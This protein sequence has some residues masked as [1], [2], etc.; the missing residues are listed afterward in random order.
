MLLPSLPF[1][2]RA[3]RVLSTTR[4]FS[5]G[6]GRPCRPDFRNSTRV[7]PGGSA[8]A[9]PPPPLRGLIL[10]A[11]ATPFLLR[12]R[13]GLRRIRP[14][15]RGSHREAV[16]ALGR[17]GG[18]SGPRARGA[19]GSSL[20]IGVPAF[21]G[22]GGSVQARRLRREGRPPAGYLLL[23]R[24][25]PAGPPPGDER[26]L[27]PS[28][29]PLPEARSRRAARGRQREPRGPEPAR[30]GAGA[31]PP[32]RP[33]LPA[34][35]R[36]AL[37]RKRRQSGVTAESPSPPRP[38]AGPA[39]PLSDLGQPSPSDWRPVL[40]L[41]TSQRCCEAPLCQLPGSLGSACQRPRRFPARAGD[42]HPGPPGRPAPSSGDSDAVTWPFC[43]FPS[44]PPLWN[45][46][47]GWLML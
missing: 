16:P 38:Q 13:P 27:P 3:L 8:S 26:T 5:L 12:A 33:G 18:A 22:G 47:R 36:P 43:S 41:P 40:E 42:S 19:L 7:I 11:F 34:G 21:G 29:R 1:P 45:R 20:G 23:A 30:A 44:S 6:R 35:L 24:L 9:Q 31:R 25:A 37:G 2:S 10:S 14:P 17:N 46:Q 28:E 39:P 15:G 4:G 32:W